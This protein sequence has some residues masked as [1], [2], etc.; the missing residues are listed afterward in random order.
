MLNFFR[1]KDSRN[2]GNGPAS[3]AASG[4]AATSGGASA[5][6]ASGGTA[7]PYDAPAPYAAGSTATSGASVP[8][9]NSPIPYGTSGGSSTPHN[10]AA[11]YANSGNTS[12][13]AGSAF[14]PDDT[15]PVPEARRTPQEVLATFKEAPLPDAI[16]GLLFR[17]SMAAP[18]EVD[19][20]SF[21]RYAARLLT[22]AGAA[23][24]RAI[25]VEHPLE[26]RHLSLTGLYWISFDASSMEPEQRACVLRVESALNRL[27]LVRQTMRA[28]ARTP[29]HPEEV[30]AQWDWQ[31]IRSITRYAERRLEGAEK[32]NELLTISGATG[33]RGGNWDVCTR[34]AHA[35]ETLI[36]P[37]RLE[38]RFD[39]DVASGTVVADVTLP[40]PDQMP[41]SQWVEDAFAW[42]DRTSQQPAAAAA[43]AL[44]LAALIAAAAFGSSVGITRA[45]VNGHEG[46]LDSETVLSLE[47][48]R[49]TFV[50]G[51]MPSIK[52]GATAAAGTEYD[53][54]TLF[55]LLKPTRFAV[56]PDASGHNLP[57][58]PLA[59]NLP[60]RHIPLA[61]DTRVLPPELAELLHADRAC[62]LDVM[63]EQ[64]L[65]MRE[66]FEA[67]MDDRDDSPLLATAQLEDIAQKGDELTEANLAALREANPE[68]AAAGKV[69]PLY[70][71]GLF[72]RYLVGLD[73]EPGMR[74]ARASDMAHAAR[75]ALSH[76]YTG[77]GDTDGGIA[78]AKACLEM[79]PSGPSAYQDLITAYVEADRYDLVI[80]VAKQALRYAVIDD[81]IFY[82][83][84]RLAYAFWQTGRREEAA[85]CYS[86]VPRASSMGEPAARE[87]SDLLGEMGDRDPVDGSE[88]ASVLRAAG[89]PLAPTD[90][91][92][93]LMAK[94]MVGLCDAGLPLAASPM[95]RVI[96]HIKR[97]DIISSVASSLKEGA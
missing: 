49:M 80:D 43:Y 97:N 95:A 12:A 2:S 92:V 41:R 54:A 19:V 8:G 47:F 52:E 13:P 14:E 84:Y 35:C 86:R 48:D 74:Y 33:V 69:A 83:Y 96:G 39:V 75:A 91:A 70:C 67:A 31:N 28:E 64:D 45:L 55:G 58:E 66:R 16:D 78:Q 34:F 15:A 68:A 18:G 94:A 73:A 87:L 56:S 9:N 61:E 88:A 20:T 72:A 62:D 10:A 82:L 57:V 32:E 37:Y 5:S 89:V 60:E 6:D 85:A 90:E 77:M 26:L 44:R 4:G 53:P 71:E 24:L 27:I 7:T 59:A 40:C 36:L 1:K 63:S 29:Y 30:Y 42:Q 65:A 22:E 38:Y 93:E 79:A 3:D 81:G 11:P 25:A 50:M 51:V 23:N 17:V 21:E 46:S 76:L